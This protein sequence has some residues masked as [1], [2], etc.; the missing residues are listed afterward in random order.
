LNILLSKE[1]AFQPCP[2][3]FHHQT[4]PRTNAFGLSNFANLYHQNPLPLPGYTEEVFSTLRYDVNQD[5][6][7]DFPSVE[8]IREQTEKRK[9]N[10]KRSLPKISLNVFP[11]W[12][13]CLERRLTGIDSDASPDPRIMDLSKDDLC[14]SAGS[15]QTQVKITLDV[16]SVMLIV[17]R[18][19]AI[20]AEINFNVY[21]NMLYNL[22]HDLH[23][24]YKG[25]PISKMCGW[26]FG[27]FIEDNMRFD[28]HLL[29]PKL[30]PIIGKINYA[31]HKVQQFFYDK[32]FLK[33]IRGVIPTWDPQYEFPMAWE[34][35]KRLCEA[36]GDNKITPG[37]YDNR[38]LDH[39]YP[40][41][42][43]HLRALWL[44]MDQIL[45]E[46][47]DNQS[48]DDCPKE[49]K[50]LE[51]MIFFVDAKNLKKKLF[52]SSANMEDL[53]KVLRHKVLISDI[54]RSD[55]ISSFHILTLNMW[56][57]YDSGLTSV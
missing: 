9:A 54:A 44:R 28:I 42:A 21:S 49:A 27:F 22:K 34:Q 47:L 52:T 51:G 3:P 31:T 6:R 38:R 16:D 4:E 13:S 8:E 25:I 18:L 5:N 41:A 57:R 12:R 39:P 33:A 53:Q 24:F 32:I 26:C 35:E 36:I 20:K 19:D 40:V 11:N 23:I 29:L 17:H 55:D 15:A 50:E 30:S 37:E 7:E 1:K 14:I 56:I 43:E 48:K 2:D 10:C 45:K 46:M